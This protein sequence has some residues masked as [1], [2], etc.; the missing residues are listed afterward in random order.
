VPAAAED[1]EEVRGLAGV[2]AA[3]A[4]GFAA[5]WGEDEAGA[6]EDGCEGEGGEEG[7]EEERAEHCCGGGVGW[8]GGV[9]CWGGSV[10]SIAGGKMWYSMVWER[11]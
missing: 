6:E 4:D 10:R 3:V 2:A 11:R 1:D 7:E 5:G 9:R 8:A